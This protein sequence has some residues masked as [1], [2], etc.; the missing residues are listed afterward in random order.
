M[1]QFLVGYMSKLRK[2]E[3]VFSNG[4]ANDGWALGRF[5]AVEGWAVKEISR[6]VYSHFYYDSFC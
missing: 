4:Y 3:W 2:R 6:G 5:D 1:A